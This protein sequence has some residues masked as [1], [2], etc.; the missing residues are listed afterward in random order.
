MRKAVK[1]FVYLILALFCAL[2]T[3]A[4]AV[5]ET[6][7]EGNEDYYYKMCA[8]SDLTAAEIA[9]CKEFMNYVAKDQNDLQSQ[10]DEINAQIAEAKKEISKYVGQIATL[11]KEVDELNVQIEELNVQIETLTAE[12][13]SLTIQITEK[14]NQ[15]DELRNRVNQRMIDAQPTMRMNQYLDFIMGSKTFEELLRRITGMDTLME[16]DEAQ[17]IELKSLMDSLE[18]DK[19]NLEA[20]KVLLDEAKEEVVAKRNQVLVQKQY[21][22]SLKQHWLE[23]EQELIAQGNQIAGDLNALK[24]KLNEI[25]D[26]I[27]EIPPSAGWTKPISSGARY[28]AGTWAYPS[29]GIHLGMDLAADAKTPIKAAGNGIVITSVNG[30]PTYSFG[31]GDMCGSQ[32]GGT[33]GGGNQIIMLTRVDGTLYAVKYLHL[34]KDTLVSVGTQVSAGDK[35]AEIGSSGNSSGRHVHVE[36]YRL[37][38]M[39]MQSYLNSWNGNLSFGCGWGSSA[40]KTRCSVKGSAPCRER[41]EDFF[42]Y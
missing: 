33:A 15:I 14:Q 30:C 3:T 26:A 8:A 17:R 24:D 31:L 13:E 1:R 36:I 4:P 18:A 29:G 9:T 23:Q 25:G 6:D 16:Y 42:G 19:K 20:S 41:P 5:A 21:I 22:E 11:Q 40:L 38:T 32:Y 27:N 35:L 37:G 7:F 2:S 10:L 34:A 12:I 39:S 28:T